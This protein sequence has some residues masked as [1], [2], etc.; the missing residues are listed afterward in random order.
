MDKSI[1]CL[2]VTIFGNLEKYTD[3][4]SKAHC[5]IFY[6]YGNRNGT[7]ITDE[8][9]D[10]LTNTLP[11]API[12][13][14][15]DQELGDYEDHGER[16]DNGRIYGVVPEDPNLQY[17]DFT[18]D[19]GITRSYATCDV[20]IFTAL[21]SEASEI[22]GKSL[23][24]EL[25]PASIK[26]EKRFI[27]GEEYYVYTTGSFLGLQVL[28]TNVEPCFEGA[29]F[30]TLRDGLSTLLS[31]IQQSVL[32]FQKVQGGTQTMPKNMFRLSDDEKYDLL[33]IALN[34]NYSEVGGWKIDAQICAVYDDYAL[35]IETDGNYYRCYYEK[36]NEANTVTM[37]KKT[38]CMLIDVTETEYSALNAIRA[39]NEDNYENIDTKYSAAIA[40]NTTSSEKIA[41]QESALEDIH[42][43]FTA[44]KDSYNTLEGE[45]E[46]L[47]NFK[48][49]AD[50]AAKQAIIA[51]YSLKLPEAIITEFTAKIDSFTVDTLDRELAYALVKSDAAIFSSEPQKGFIPTPQVEQG[52][53]AIL[54][55]YKK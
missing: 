8:F 47:R 35:T 42:K 33:F 49:A 6:K 38:R 40:L 3:T 54:A 18:D 31:Q 39:L 53:G 48:T 41:Q 45:V 24:M 15:Y 23:S 14:I 51:K 19:D 34:P 11:Y 28:G 7:Y 22:V 2:P 17:M 21:Y 46:G 10:I 52:L 50:T 27:D 9:A 29:Q 44:L 16:R 30:F 32:N 37:K 1:F 4:I 36:D 43:T 20:L 25:Y 5:R 55:K 26:G 13:G 12:K